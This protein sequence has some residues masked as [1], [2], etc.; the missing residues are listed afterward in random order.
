[1]NQAQSYTPFISNTGTHQ[2]WNTEEFCLSIKSALG[3]DS[4]ISIDL[5]D[6]RSLLG[7]GDISLGYGHTIAREGAAI[8]ACK[9]SIHGHLIENPDLLRTATG[10]LVIIRTPRHATVKLS[11]VRDGLREIWQH[12]SDSAQCIYAYIHGDIAVD[13]IEVYTLVANDADPK[14]LNTQLT[15]TQNLTL[16][17]ALQKLSRLAEQTNPD[18]ILLQ[19]ACYLLAKHQRSSVSFIQRKLKIGYAMASKLLEQ[20][21]REKIIGAISPEGLRP[22]LVRL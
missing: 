2:P 21:E 5:D 16:D 6:I 12:S 14:A 3:S 9:A 4:I 15:A 11:E 18:L 7:Q 19:N 8:K 22:V 1:M 10:I 20:L 17:E 13:A